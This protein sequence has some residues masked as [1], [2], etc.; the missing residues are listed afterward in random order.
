MRGSDILKVNTY[1]LG[2][3]GF[4]AAHP[5]TVLKVLDGLRQA[6]AWAD[7]HRPEVAQALHDVTGVPLDAQQLAADRAEFGIFEI[8]S[9]IIAHQQETADRFFRLG[10]IPKQIT[11][12]DAVWAPPRS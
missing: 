3:K 1:F 5:E 10:L 9:D 7:A 6:A 11:V 4:V 12:A 8:T 2:N